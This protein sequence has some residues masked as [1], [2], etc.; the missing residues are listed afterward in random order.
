MINT[1]HYHFL[2]S[3]PSYL[4][5]SS[6]FF[7]CYQF[8]LSSKVQTKGSTPLFIHIFS[9]VLTTGILGTLINALAITDRGMA[10]T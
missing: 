2:S 4:T 3:L 1:A 5:I 9:L 6:P 8:M 10:L 7:S